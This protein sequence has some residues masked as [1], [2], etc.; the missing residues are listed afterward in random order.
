[1]GTAVPEIQKNHLAWRRALEI[2]P[3]TLFAIQAVTKENLV[4]FLLRL[5]ASEYAALGKAFAVA[6]PR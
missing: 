6:R 4:H 2:Q 5:G 3:D 1:M